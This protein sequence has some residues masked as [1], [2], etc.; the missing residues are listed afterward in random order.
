RNPYHHM[1]KHYHDGRLQ[2]GHVNDPE[3]DARLVFQVFRNQLTALAKQNS[4]QPDA[5]TAF[6]FLTT[7]M[8]NSDG[9]D[10][11]CREVRGGPAPGRVEAEEALSRLLERR[12]CAWQVEQT[13]DRLSS[14]QLGWP[15]AYALSSIL[16]AGGDSVMPPWVRAQFREAAPIVR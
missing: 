1:V 5:V 15:L 9:F 4:E 14:P 12:A 8:E 11:V 3:L 7:R 16:V 10:A 6:H 2:A 13:L